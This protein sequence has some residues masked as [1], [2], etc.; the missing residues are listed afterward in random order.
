MWDA[1]NR[2]DEETDKEE[3]ERR[4]RDTFPWEIFLYARS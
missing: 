2:E 3:R 4:G 1:F